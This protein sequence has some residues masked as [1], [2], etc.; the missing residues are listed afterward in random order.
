MTT[1]P[2]S[3]EFNGC[4]GMTHPSGEGGGPQSITAYIH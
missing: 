4:A 1:E 2:H 3:V